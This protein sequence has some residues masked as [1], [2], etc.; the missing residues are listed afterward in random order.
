MEN[1]FLNT[2]KEKTNYKLTE[3][4]GVAHKSTLDAVYNM[5]ALG[6]SFRSRTD[7]DCIL[8]FKSA[9]EEDK[10]LALKCLFYLRD[11][12]CRTRRKKIF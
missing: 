12:R 1:S 6:G 2:L 4:G 8:L 5:F 7:E 11:I 9:L 3:N 10:N